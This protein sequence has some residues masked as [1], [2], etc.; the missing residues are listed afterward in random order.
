MFPVYYWH[1]PKKQDD[2]GFVIQDF[3]GP[4]RPGDDR[5]AIIEVNRP[6]ADSATTGLTPAQMVEMKA[7][8]YRQSHYAAIA[9]MSLTVAGEPVECLRS[10]ELVTTL[11][12][13]GEGRVV[14]L[15]FVGGKAQLEHFK[16]MIAGAERL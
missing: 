3:P 10:D 11:Y 14:R 9:T 8:E 2:Y 1:V 7:E 6:G 5:V 4:L 13:Y 12:C 16:A 15:F